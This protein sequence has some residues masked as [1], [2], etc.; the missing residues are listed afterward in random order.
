MS[1]AER[2][3][4]ELAL[5]GLR[6]SLAADKWLLRAEYDGRDEDDEW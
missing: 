3:V 6:D 2:Q 4:R 1:E 5:E